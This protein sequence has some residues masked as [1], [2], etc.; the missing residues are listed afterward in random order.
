MHTH[1]VISCAIYCCNRHTPDKAHSIDFCLLVVLYI[2]ADYCHKS[3][4]IIIVHGD[5]SG[6]L[7]EMGN[8]HFQPPESF[9]FQK[10]NKWPRW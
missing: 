6:S 8:V 7:I 2:V 10:P 3:N 1:I 4:D 9:D 5:K